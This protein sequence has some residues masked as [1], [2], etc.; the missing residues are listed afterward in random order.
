MNDKADA[1][2]KLQLAAIEYATMC[3]LMS[4]LEQTDERTALLLAAQD[5]FKEARAEWNEGQK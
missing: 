4:E 1:L 3:D 2:R 5:R